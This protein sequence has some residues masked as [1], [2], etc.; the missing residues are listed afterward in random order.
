MI[1]DGAAFYAVKG[2][3]GGKL[4]EDKPRV[5]EAK[6]VGR[7]NETTPEE[8]AELEAQSKWQKKFDKDYALTE[9]DAR[10]K[11]Y[12]DPMLAQKYSDRSDDLEFP[13]YSQPKLDGIRCITSLDENGNVI[14]KTRNGKVIDAIPHVLDELKQFFLSSPNSILD[15]ELYNHDLKDN[16][17]EK[18][19]L[20]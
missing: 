15:G 9:S 14:A 5:C 2:L 16:L 4:V 1:I 20:R 7:S 12:Y 11:T 10:S 17:K 13:L 8:Q 3:V 19:F 18:I 6:N